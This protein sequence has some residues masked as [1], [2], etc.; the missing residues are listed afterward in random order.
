MMT[1]RRPWVFANFCLS[2]LCTWKVGKKIIPMLTPPMS[3]V[4]PKFA[5]FKNFL[6]APSE[7]IF[8]LET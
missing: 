3:T 6:E 1:V 2:S 8:K 5:F 7:N 4:V